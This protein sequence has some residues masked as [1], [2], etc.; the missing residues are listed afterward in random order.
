M[1]TKEKVIQALEALAKRYSDITRADITECFIKKDDYNLY[2]SSYGKA[3]ARELTGFGSFSHCSV[4]QVLAEPISFPNCDNC[5]W[6]HV[7]KTTTGFTV[8]PCTAHNTY[9]GIRDAENPKQLKYAFNARSVFI[10][11][12][13]RIHK[14][15]YL[16]SE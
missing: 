6:H 12:Q 8:N 15:S 16:E 5:F 9:R 7:T 11:E 3:V 10:K 2:D 4:C 13:L 14:Q 1:S